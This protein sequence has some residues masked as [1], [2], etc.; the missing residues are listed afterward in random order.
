MGFEAKTTAGGGG[1]VGAE[2]GGLKSWSESDIGDIGVRTADE[3]PA[4][5]LGRI[6]DFELSGSLGAGLRRYFGGLERFELR[7]LNL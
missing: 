5:L 6:S 7:T 1:G 2:V 3:A 4:E